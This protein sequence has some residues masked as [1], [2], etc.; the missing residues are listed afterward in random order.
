MGPE[1][2]SIGR[3]SK[4]DATHQCLSS[5]P[6]AAVDNGIS[7]FLGAIIANSNETVTRMHLTKFEVYLTSSFRA[8]DQCWRHMT[9]DAGTS[10]SDTNSSP[11]NLC[12]WWA[13]DG[14]GKLKIKI[15]NHNNVLNSL[16]KAILITAWFLI[17]IIV[18]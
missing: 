14:S 8:V 4:K 11:L 12:F 2:I 17:C 16:K 15:K 6:Y 10:L 18:N 7:L 5:R 1:F 3:G 13:K 9:T